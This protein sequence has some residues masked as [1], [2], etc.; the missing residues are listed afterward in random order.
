MGV[1]VSDPHTL[2]SGFQLHIKLVLDPDPAPHQT[3]FGSGFKVVKGK[4]ETWSYRFSTN[5]FRNCALNKI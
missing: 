3:R 1:R 4:Q 2:Y 5:L